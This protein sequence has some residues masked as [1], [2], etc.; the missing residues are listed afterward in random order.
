MRASLPIVGHHRLRDGVTAQD[1][2]ANLQAKGGED[3][4]GTERAGAGLSGGRLAVQNGHT[5]GSCIT[6]LPP[7]ASMKPPASSTK[8]I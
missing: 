7:S 6:R 8:A 1:I 2:A 5:P 3:G 4:R